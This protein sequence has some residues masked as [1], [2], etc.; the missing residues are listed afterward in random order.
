MHE[1]LEAQHYRLAYWRVAAEEINYRRF[2]QINEL[3]GIRIELPT[4]FEATHRLVLGADPAA[5]NPRPAD[6]PHRRSVRSQAVPRAAAAARPRSAGPAGASARA[7]GGA[8][9]RAAAGTSRGRQTEDGDAG[10]F[11][12]VVEKILAPHERLREDWPIAGTTGY[13]FLNRVHGLFVDPDGR[14]AAAAHLRALRRRARVLRGNRLRQQAAGDGFR[15]G[16]RAARARQRVQPA[17]REQLAH[18]RLHP[19]RPATSAARGGGLLPGLSHLR[20]RRRRLAA[21]PPRH[22]VGDRARP[23]AQ[24]ARRQDA[25]STSS[26]RR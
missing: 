12:V 9:A 24:R 6:R 16:E 18:P 20:R 1:L 23:A 2:F 5:A 26:R 17:D 10:S 25:C 8:A 15:A 11:F 14:G 19:R 13:E 4:V 22:R 21:G 7:D 3:A